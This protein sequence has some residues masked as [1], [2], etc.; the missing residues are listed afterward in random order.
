MYWNSWY[1]AF[2]SRILFHFLLKW[3]VLSQPLFSNVDARGTALR[4]LP[5]AY[6]AWSLWLV[7]TS[8]VIFWI[9]LSSRS[10]R[11]WFFVSVICSQ[12]SKQRWIAL[13]SRP[14][15]DQILSWLTLF[16]IGPGLK[17]FS[18]LPASAP[19]GTASKKILSALQ[20]RGRT[21]LEWRW[22]WQAIRANQ[23]YTNL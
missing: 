11:T 22:K 10:W 4:L 1:Y 20:K 15:M 18:K 5:F 14:S 19:S 16:D 17:S 23:V 7:S 9:P 8:I 2:Y 21:L 12:S 6:V 3:W 13:F